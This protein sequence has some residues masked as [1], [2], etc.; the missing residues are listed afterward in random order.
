MFWYIRIYGS[1]ILFNEPI[2]L[3]LW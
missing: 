3:R 2:I 1:K